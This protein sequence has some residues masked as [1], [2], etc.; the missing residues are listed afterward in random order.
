MKQSLDNG[1]Q[2]RLVY[3]MILCAEM[4]MKRILSSISYSRITGENVMK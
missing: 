3:W 1:S 2:V 4:V